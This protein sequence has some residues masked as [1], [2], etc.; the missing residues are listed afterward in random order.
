M[1]TTKLREYNG[2]LWTPARFRSFVT[3]AL[4]TAS[5][6]WPPKF[7]ALKQALE[8]KQVNQKTGKLAN[9]YRCAACEGLFVSSDVNVDHIKPVV[10]PKKGFKTW[11]EY[12]DRLFCELSNFQ[13]LC[14]P[15]H[16]E[17]TQKEKEQRKK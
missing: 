1:A 3:S 10:D 8:G 5:Q 14:R 15:C 17:K 12:I 7:E 2:G 9:H 13:V 6:R 16:K 4:R 11:D